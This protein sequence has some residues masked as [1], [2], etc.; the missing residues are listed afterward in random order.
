MIKLRTIAVIFWTVLIVGLIFT[1]A[2]SNGSPTIP[3]PTGVQGDELGA[4]PTDPDLTALMLGYE[5]LKAAGGG[6]GH[7]EVTDTGLA[8]IGIFD[9]MTGHP[10]NQ[11][12]RIARVTIEESDGTTNTINIIDK[13]IW[14]I[15]NYPV[16][17][18]AYIPGYIARTI[19]KTNGN[20][21]AIPLALLEN[22]IRP[23]TVIGFTLAYNNVGGIGQNGQPWKIYAATSHI[24]RD[25]K[26]SY[27]GG[28][29]TSSPV[30]SAN[31][32]QSISGIPGTV[33][34]AN[35]LQNVGAM[36]F[37]Y[38]LDPDSPVE[39]DFIL[40]GCSYS[41]IGSL[42]S[43]AAGGW[44]LNFTEEGQGENYGT[45]NYSFTYL[46]GLAPTSILGR[47]S[48]YPGG[49]KDASRELIPYYPQLDVRVQDEGSGYNGTYDLNAYADPTFVDREVIYATMAYSDGVTETRFVPWD[50][51]GA[52][53]DIAFGNPAVMD[54]SL[55]TVLDEEGNLSFECAW[56]DATPGDTE[57]YQV[58]QLITQ[59]DGPVWEIYVPMDVREIIADFKV[60]LPASAL[61]GTIGEIPMVQVER[62]E[63]SDISLDALNFQAVWANSSAWITSAPIE[64]DVDN[65]FD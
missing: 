14:T 22:S 30:L 27:G 49:T 52:A 2:C 19:F 28:Y 61:T 26:I 46:P 32:Q 48:L 15:T 36:A 31:S 24:N 18:T 12:S 55:W 20:V 57:G 44:V 42:A 37:I 33:L 11:L 34:Y 10:L 8:V 39:S 21:I 16:T 23:A 7:V 64:S 6:V 59:A 9:A 47:L 54:S 50:S 53:P 3:D 62:V 56:T 51:E 38:E 63:S 40:S 1:G 17:V 35:P 43:G 5:A 58:L 13:A 25:W 65:M 41:N 45:G 60:G 4:T 29:F